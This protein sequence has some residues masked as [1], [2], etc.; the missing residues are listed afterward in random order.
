MSASPE[1]PSVAVS[2]RAD[3][4]RD[5]IEAFGPGAGRS[6][7]IKTLILLGLLACVFRRELRVAALMAIRNSDWA[8]GLVAPV[9]ILILLLRRR[10]ELS[11]SLARGSVWGV[12]LLLFSL[13][14]FAATIW[15]YDYAY[16]RA[17]TL[18]PAAAGV[19]LATCGRRVL[20]HSVPALL[21]LLL[22]IP[23]GQ[24]A[25]AA[26]VIRT[27]T[28]TL[29]AARFVLDR[30][31]GVAVNLDG[32]EL[33]FTAGNLTGI[34]ALGQTRHGAS[35]LVT[36][37]FIGVLVA[38]VRV[39]LIWQIIVFAMAAAPVAFLCNFL[40]VLTAGAI[41]IY[42]RP[43]PVSPVNRFVAASVS[44]ALAYSIFVLIGW[45]MS[46]LFI[47]DTD[48]EDQD[49]NTDAVGL[50]ETAAGRA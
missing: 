27:E 48:A 42:A 31:P 21:L 47:E 22:S 24:R 14:L 2:G 45:L 50:D 4:G 30:L 36:Y 6:A 40:R 17:V 39:R 34:V 26:L 44:F 13:G 19:I 29:S 3:D 12:L 38:F 7:T 37:V 23:I 25:Y 46:R 5:A 43:D 9:A 16:P 1:R 33:R 15:P 18:V 41:A 35:Y 8:H 28:T 11:R 32:P 49:E 10:S 20:L